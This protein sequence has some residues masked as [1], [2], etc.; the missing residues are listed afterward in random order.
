MNSGS[1][2]CVDPALAPE[3]WSIVRPM[4]EAAYV[5]VDEF[6][7]ADFL[8]SVMAGD[9]LLWISNEGDRIVAVLATALVKRPSG[10]ACRMVVCG[11]RR[12]EIWK[13]SGKAQIEKYARDEGCVKVIS[14]GRPGWAR[15]LHGY[16][17]TRIS[18][19]RVL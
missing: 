13:D 19:E 7:P 14:E 5:E 11:G 17:Q 10:L 15:A 1:L 4:I 18:L 8:Q 3:V 9:R 16:K 6:M 12:M 2:I